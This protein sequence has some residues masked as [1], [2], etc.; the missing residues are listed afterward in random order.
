MTLIAYFTMLIVGLVLGL[1]G[2]GGAILTMPI[3]VYLF[4]VPPVLA[5]SY[6]LFIVGCASIFGVWRYHL[7][8]LVDYKTAIV[9]ILPSFV[10]TYLARQ[11]LLPSIPSAVAHFGTFTLGKDQLIL[12]VFAIVMA[13]AAVPMLKPQGLRSK[14]NSSGISVLLLLALGF[15]VGFVAGFVGA[16][17]G[18]LI[19]PALVIVGGLPMNVA[20]ATSLFI[21]SANSLVGFAG[22][23]LSKVAIDWM[24]LTTVT[25]ASAVGLFAGVKAS[26]F[27]PPGVLK[28][29]FGWFV[30]AMGTWILAHQFL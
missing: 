22:D 2:G 7:Q 23:L 5:T 18:F 29:G 30:L 9:F 27:I 12:I 15:A 4:A 24:F 10:G 11:I 26:R 16:G 25:G 21:I 3:L 20:V 13:A 8:G 19:I 28:V 1:I 6:S 17:G 14:T